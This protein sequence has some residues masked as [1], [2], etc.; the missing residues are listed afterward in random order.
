MAMTVRRITLGA[1]L[2]QIRNERGLSLID[3]GKILSKDPASI[4]RTETGKGGVLKP[5]E[6]KAVLD[7]FGITDED[8]REELLQLARAARANDRSWW[9]D[10]TSHLRPKFRTWLHLEESAVRMDHYTALN[11][12]GL[13]QTEG[14][15]RAQLAGQPDLDAQVAVRLGRQQVF[16]KPEPPDYWAIL[17]EA[18]LHRM[19][20]GP[21]VMQ[22]QLET[23]VAWSR[24]PS[25]TI[26]VVPFSRGSYWAYGASYTVVYIADREMPP[27]VAVE[28]VHTTSY[29]ERPQEVKAHTVAFDQQRA[30][31]LAPDDSLD[32]IERLAAR[33]Q[34]E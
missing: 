7:L 28:G 17:D 29:M 4:S 19:V 11:M 20:G 10:Y 32:L 30:V 3:V 16:D 9:T 21:K 13:F 14:F 1:R 33:Y 26:Q 24:H 6:M 31:G 12:P 23:L 22:E 18:V 2:R 5:L 34:E 27:M 25:V 15:A 8:E